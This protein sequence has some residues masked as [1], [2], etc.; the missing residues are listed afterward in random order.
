MLRFSAV[1][2]EKPPGYTVTRRTKG[3]IKIPDELIV[4]RIDN[5]G[6]SIN[7]HYISKYTGTNKVNNLI[8]DPDADYMFIT[9]DDTPS[10]TYQY[11]IDNFLSNITD[12][13]NLQVGSMEG[14]NR[15]WATYEYIM[16]H[17]VLN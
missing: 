15:S 4:L 5:Q 14:S 3:V 10:N 16:Y 8:N 2:G 11:L 13:E 12:I 17:H 6:A 1:I 9:E 7:G